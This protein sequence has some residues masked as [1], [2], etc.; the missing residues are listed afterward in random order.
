[1]PDPR[2]PFDEVDEDHPIRPDDDLVEVDDDWVMLDDWW[3]VNIV[4]GVGGPIRGRGGPRDSAEMILD[5][6]SQFGDEIVTL[7][8]LT[9]AAAI[10]AMAPLVAVEIAA[11]IQAGHIAIPYAG[12]IKKAVERVDEATKPMRE[13]FNTEVDRLEGIISSDAFQGVLSA[14]RITHR[15]GMT[16]SPQYRE[17]IE[18]LFSATAELSRTVMGDA[19]TL[20]SAL[21]LLNLVIEDANRLTGNDVNLA[22][23]EW[24]IETQRLVDDVETNSSRYARSPGAFWYDFNAN[25][26]K[27]Q[28]ERGTAGFQKRSNI[29]AGIQEVAN[30]AETLA[31]GLDSRF[32]EYRRELDPFLDPLKVR[33]L[34]TLRRD[35]RLTFRDP[36]RN[37]NTFIN[38]EIPQTGATV[39]LL[40]ET[41][42]EL[43]EK[44][45]GLEQ[46]TRDPDENDEQQREFSQS[47]FARI[48]GEGL[49]A[50]IERDALQEANLEVD[51]IRRELP[52]D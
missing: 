46:L 5:E 40:T 43:T 30:K 9:T 17:Q 33:E 44:V 24:F 38:E 4:S 37:L 35:Y 12:A 26:L 39:V 13:R 52:T 47:R 32:I 2:D 21:G 34:D 11:A 27:P 29:M 19:N 49:P 31:T 6:I 51:R 7:S 41:T 15:V 8:R 50:D 1:M 48:L 25:Y 14:V 16:I 42:D 18:R 3:A 23:Q 20:N 22:E 45:E 28:Q 36:L 10:A